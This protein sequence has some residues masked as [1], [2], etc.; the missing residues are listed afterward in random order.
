MR[1]LKIHYLEDNASLSESTMTGFVPLGDERCSAFPIESEYMRPMYYDRI[2]DACDAETGEV[3][4]IKELCGVRPSS[5]SIEVRPV[6]QLRPKGRQLGHGR[7]TFKGQRSKDSN[8]FF[9]RY[10]HDAIWNHFRNKLIGLFNGQCFACG[11]PEGLQLDHHVPLIHGGRREPGNI[12]MLCFRCNQKKWDYLPEQFYSQDELIHLAPLLAQ[13]AEVLAFE[14]EERRWAADP[15]RYL[16]DIGLSPLLI[17]EI[18][19]NPHHTWAMPVT[20][21]SQYE[22]ATAHDNKKAPRAD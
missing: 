17:E 6:R 15:F 16:H 2:N 7:E 10:R 5:G 22:T 13:E 8:E 1:T 4:S 3:I 18:R 19:T 20:F 21:P 11:S 9:M 12:V 14:F